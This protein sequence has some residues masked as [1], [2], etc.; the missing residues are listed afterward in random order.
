MNLFRVYQVSNDIT[1]ILSIFIILIMI[2]AIY[3]LARS[4]FKERTRLRDE[5]SMT[6]EGVLT[7][8]EMTSLITSQIARAGKES[9][10][11]LVYLDLDKFTDFI[12]AFGQSESEKILEKIV[13]NI[14][15]VIPKGVKIARM[16]NDE[17]LIFLTMDYDRTEA[18][19]LA[20]RVKQAIGRPIRLFGDTQISATASISVAFYPIHGSNL[21]DLLSSLK[22]ATYII[23]KNG[24]N[25]IKVY[26]DE[27]STLG[28]EHVEYYYQIKHA[29]Q[30]KEFQLYYHP[31]IDLNKNDLFGVEALIRWNHPEHGLLSPF[32]F[33]GI[34]EQSG[35]VHW[36]GL[37]GLETLIKTYQELKQE[38][39]KR[40]IKF[41][42][43]LSPKQLMSETLPTEFQK[44]LKKYRMNADSIILEI[45]EFAVFEKQETIFK[46]LRKLK[47]MGFQLAIDGFGLDYNTLSKVEELDIDIIKLDN[48]FLKEEESY[49][50][51]KFAS[52]LVEFAKKNNYT[53]ICEV[54]ESKEM[55][56]E[57]RTYNINIM[58]G[59]YFSKPLS[60]EGL[61]GYIGTEGWNKI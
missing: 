58:Q 33:L 46:N 22:I 42:M 16:Q 24:G 6:M 44:I 31:I 41:S 52:L 48:E 5:R 29:I 14:E 20:N 47:E 25:N 55:A 49:M 36:I 13:K 45:I 43:N 19:D 3:F 12:N 21:K 53:V 38:F 28:G 32:K 37:W 27:M 23:K 30:H 8:A 7:R 54:I 40:E 39:P 51:A 17:F 10:F 2:T 1:I 61:R 60:A 56:D 26:S 50:K 18:V 11:S 15:V 59:F 57:A 34:M 4:F 35:D 9:Q